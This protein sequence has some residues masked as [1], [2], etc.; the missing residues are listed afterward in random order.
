M[1]T[2][3]AIAAIALVAVA[4]GMSSFAPAMADNPRVYYCHADSNGDFKV[5]KAGVKSGHVD[6]ADD[7]GPFDTKAEALAACPIV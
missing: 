1:K 4:M 7:L 3:Y 6:H 2:T 5:V